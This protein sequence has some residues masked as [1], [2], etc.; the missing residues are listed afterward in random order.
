MKKIHRQSEDYHDEKDHNAPSYF[1][2]FQFLIGDHSIA[3]KS[4]YKE[5]D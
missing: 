1:Y 5:C 3:S 2:F 4:S